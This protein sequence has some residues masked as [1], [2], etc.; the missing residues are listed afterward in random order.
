M[1]SLKALSVLAALLGA[2]VLAPASAGAADDLSSS[3]VGAEAKKNLSECP[4]G[5]SKFQVGGKRP[6]AFKSAPPP[7]ERK[8]ASNAKPTNPTEAMAAGQRDSRKNR[9]QARSRA[10]LITEIQGLERLYK[11]TPKKSADRPQLIFGFHIWESR[12]QFMLPRCI[13]VEAVAGRRHALSIQSQQFMSFFLNRFLGLG[14]DARPIRLAQFAQNRRT[15]IRPNIARQTVSLMN[16]HEHHIRAAV[17]D[18][19]ILAF[20]AF[21]RAPPHS[22]ESSD[23]VIHMHHIITRLHIGI[24]GFGQSGAGLCLTAARLRP[25][26]AENFCIR[27]QMNRLSRQL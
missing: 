1:K 21:Y 17:F 7:R 27:Q 3:C 14:G 8:D 18:H 15:I 4:G 13:R 23:A 6:A 12:F 19:Q 16:R 26:P 9:L 11:N 5:P 22:G 25:I 2:I 10:L 24:A 20:I